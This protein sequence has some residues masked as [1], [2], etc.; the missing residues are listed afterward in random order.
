MKVGEYTFLVP[1]LGVREQRA[2]LF[3]IAG[4]AG[5]PLADLANEEMAEI[6]GDA[7][8]TVGM[9][10]MIKGLKS[11]FVTLQ[12]PRLL[13]TY[14]WMIT[15]FTRD[16]RAKV[17]YF[18]EEHQQE[19]EPFLS[20]VYDDFF[21]MKLDLE[22]QFLW[23]CLEANFLPFTVRVRSVLLALFA[24]LKKKKGDGQEESD[25]KKKDPELE[26]AT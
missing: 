3:K 25:E 20:D 10:A 6:S 14:E 9:D 26:D 17:R 13:E 7:D 8:E 15:Q 23:A 1:L 22:A 5:V 21:H 24:K 19:A 12:D 4:I 2:M 18:N 16:R 11:A